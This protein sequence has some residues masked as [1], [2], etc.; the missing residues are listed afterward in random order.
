MF[1][2]KPIEKEAKSSRSWIL[3]IELTF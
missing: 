3:Q 2:E 1:L